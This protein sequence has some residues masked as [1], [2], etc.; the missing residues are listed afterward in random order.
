MFCLVVVVSI[1]VDICRLCFCLAI[2]FKLLQLHLSC[3]HAVG[4]EVQSR[5]T[6]FQDSTETP[7][8]LYFSFLEGRKAIYV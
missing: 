8:K 4:V 5:G 2:N 7:N 6:R 3:T 1:G